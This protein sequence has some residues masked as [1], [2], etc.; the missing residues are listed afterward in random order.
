[1][2]LVLSGSPRRGGNT[3]YVCS[4]L[5]R[6]FVSMGLKTRFYRITDYRIEPCRSCRTCLSRG[7]C[8]IDDDMTKLFY[9]ELLASKAIVIASPVYFNSIPAQ[10]KAFIDRTMV[11]KRQ[12]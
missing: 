4:I 2:I 7:L 5:V 8:I 3:D 11:F 6:E 10:L 1:M 12:A 9:K